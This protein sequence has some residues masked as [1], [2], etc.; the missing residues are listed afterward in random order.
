MKAN[1]PNG[2]LLSW[3]LLELQLE[4]TLTR[5]YRSYFLVFPSTP[6]PFALLDGL[7]RQVG[8]E[9]SLVS[10][11]RELLPLKESVEGKQGKQEVT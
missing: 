9:S 5:P 8:R 3:I 2:T 10:K 4:C 6:E 7:M 1:V 11:P